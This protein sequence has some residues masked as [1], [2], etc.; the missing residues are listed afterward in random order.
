VALTRA[1]Q[2]LGVVHAGELP[3]VLGRLRAGTDGG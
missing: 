1:T 2:Q 3:P